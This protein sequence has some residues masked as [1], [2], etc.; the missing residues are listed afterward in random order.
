M[1]FRSN[2]GAKKRVFGRITAL[3]AVS[4]PE[5]RSP[6]PPRKRARPPPPHRRLHAYPAD[7][8]AAQAIRQYSWDHILG[9]SFRQAE[10]TAKWL[11]I[12]K[13]GLLDEGTAAGTPAALSATGRRADP[14]TAGDRLKARLSVCRWPCCALP[15]IDRDLAAKVMQTARSFPAVTITGP[16]AARL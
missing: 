1:L 5:A 9:H 15:M 6:M 4:R 3:E 11:A 2:T 16:R 7:F 10:K 14:P 8:L 13:T 12:I